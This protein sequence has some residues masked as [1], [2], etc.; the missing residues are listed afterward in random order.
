MH[1]SSADGVL[2]TSLAEDV[3][4]LVD[5]QRNV[6]QGFLTASKLWKTKTGNALFV[7]GLR[8]I[9]QCLK[10]THIQR[11]PLFTSTLEGCCEAANDFLRL[12]EKM[13]SLYA[14]I[15][16]ETSILSEGKDDS[17][18]ADWNAFGVQL[19]QDAVA[20]AERTQVFIM[21]AINR[22]SIPAKFFSR[23]WEEDWTHNE[24]TTSLIKAVESYLID[25]RYF[26]C[27]EY[28]YHKALVTTCKAVVCFYVRCLVEKADSVSRRRRNPDRYGQTGEKK[29]FGNAKRAL[30]RMMDD[31]VMMKDY[32]LGKTG[33]SMAIDRILNN[34]IYVL[35]LIHECLDAEDEHSIENF[36]VVIHKRTGADAL[37]TRHFVADLWLLVSNHEGR[38]QI[39]ETLVMMERDLSMVSAGMRELTGKQKSEL[40][41][42][43]LDEMLRAMYEDR[44][45]QGALPVCWTCL[46]KVESTDGNEIV[47]KKLRAITRSFAEIGLKKHH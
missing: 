21:R 44:I 23:A 30:I 27:N 15:Q 47:S 18:E 6:L 31:I 4:S 32:F 19:N 3:V 22:S 41:F 5:T 34:E 39:D 24:V 29:P 37:V 38:K 33:G 36:L 25:V 26:L 11:N 2:T 16:Q 14:H 28:L 12:A 45:V 40:S 35:E 8:Y 7:D 10:A 20:A 1:R 9:L 42:V 43:R 13:E 17:L 46:P